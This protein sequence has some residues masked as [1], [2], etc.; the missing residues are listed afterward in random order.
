M[1]T[2]VRR[3]L[4]AP[5][6]AD[7]GLH[8]DRVI[9]VEAGDGKTVLL[10]LE[11]AL[12]H[13]GLGAVVGEVDGAIGLTA[14]WSL[15][16][17]AEAPDVLWRIIR[18]LLRLTVNAEAEPMA[19][20]RAGGSRQ[21][22]QGRHCGWRRHNGSWTYCDFGA[23]SVN[24]FS[25]RCVMR[26]VISVFLSTGKRIGC[27]G[28]TLRSR[29]IYRLARKEVTSGSFLR[30]GDVYCI[31]AIHF[32]CKGGTSKE[33]VVVGGRFLYHKPLLAFLTTAGRAA[34]SECDLRDIL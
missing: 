19:A 11:E 28:S 31:P 24:L 5:A 13:V 4:S 21:S 7:V 27:A 26:Q 2:L 12:R 30:N 22:R 15:Q 32:F 33:V 34:A 6:L 20:L 14:S 18:R 29:L 3:G 8:P 25:W 16:L 23:A 9:Y 17:A 1:W 10:V